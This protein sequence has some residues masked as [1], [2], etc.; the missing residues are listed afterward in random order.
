MYRLSGREKNRAPHASLESP[1]ILIFTETS[2]Q[3]WFRLEKKR[4]IF[5]LFG[6][7]T[8]LCETEPDSLRL[9]LAVQT[10]VERKSLDVIE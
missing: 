2:R 10:V 3:A 5:V 7:G 4:I 8:P 6:T 1:Y 9:N